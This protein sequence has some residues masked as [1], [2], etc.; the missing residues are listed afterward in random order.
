MKK[1]L[2]SK[3]KA[4]VI[5]TKKSELSKEK[6]KCNICGKKQKV[7]KRI[8]KKGYYYECT[9]GAGNWVPMEWVKK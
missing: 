5:K 9:C 1:E 8:D 3:P 7:L 6:F 2:K 4:K